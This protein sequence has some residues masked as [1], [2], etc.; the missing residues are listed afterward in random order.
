MGRVACYIDGFN[1]YHA[2][3]ALDKPRLKWL[4]LKKLSESFLRQG[5]ELV[6][7]CYFTA[8]H[9]F[10]AGKCQ[11]HRRYIDALR[12]VGVEVVISKFQSVDKFCRKM[13]RSCPFLEEKQTDVAFATRIVVDAMEHFMERAVI[14]TADCD[15]VPMVR[16]VADKRPTIELTLAPPPGRMAHARELGELIPDRREINTGRLEKCLFQRTVY[17]QDGKVAANCPAGWQ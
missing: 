16:T 12:A 15:H 9:T 3:E 5:D 8:I 10:D 13:E 17:K 6:A 1:M 4:N 2:L 14:V 7:V 11:K